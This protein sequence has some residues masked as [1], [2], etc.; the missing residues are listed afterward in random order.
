MTSSQLARAQLTPSYC[1]AAPRSVVRAWG[2]GRPGIT[3]IELERARAG[4][5]AALPCWVGRWWA[6]PPSPAATTVIKPAACVCAHGNCVH[7]VE[8][9]M[10]ACGRRCTV[11]VRAVVLVRAHTH[12]HRPACAQREA[13]GVR[14]EGACAGATSAGGDAAQPST[15]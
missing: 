9:A 15:T 6:T 2:V 3:A 4:S 13:S 5:A 14:G 7:A 12:A 1:A 8:A 10:A 11:V